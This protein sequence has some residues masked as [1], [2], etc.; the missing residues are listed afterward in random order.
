MNLL[1]R[2]VVVRIQRGL[3]RNKRIITRKGVV[4]YF[5]KGVSKYATI[6]L[7]TDGNRIYQ[8]HTKLS[9]IEVVD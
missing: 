7:L 9:N 5:K 6:R 4:I 8:F 3:G 2:R 1:N